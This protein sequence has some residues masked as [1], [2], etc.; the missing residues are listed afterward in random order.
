MDSEYYSSIKNQAWELVPLPEGKT[1]IGT[2][3]VYKIKHK[4]DCYTSRLQQSFLTSHQYSAISS[5]LASANAN[6]LEV[7]QM[8]VETT[9]H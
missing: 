5:T 9:F 4:A 2:W 3:W 1:A 7:H 8:D 6:D